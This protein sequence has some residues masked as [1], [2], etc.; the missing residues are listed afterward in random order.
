MKPGSMRWHQALGMKRPSK[1]GYEARQCGMALGTEGLRQRQCGM[2][3]GIVELFCTSWW[4]RN[5]VAK[6]VWQANRG[7]AIMQQR[8]LQRAPAASALKTAIMERCQRTRSLHKFNQRQ[9]GPAS[10]QASLGSA[11]LC[12]ER[13]QSGCHGTYIHKNCGGHTLA[14]L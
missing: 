11:I 7:E 10:N 12:Y 14:V 13:T 2:A 3:P 4:K 5:C 8:E 6:K 9:G 1:H